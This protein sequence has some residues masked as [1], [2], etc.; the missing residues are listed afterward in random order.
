MV[1]LSKHDPILD[2]EP[3]LKRMFEK[4]DY[5]VIG[6]GNY[7]WANTNHPSCLI[8]GLSRDEKNDLFRLERIGYIK[9]ERTSR[10]LVS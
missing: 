4:G 1:S 8:E 6:V 5:I 10:T 7:F 3:L 2:K 9:H